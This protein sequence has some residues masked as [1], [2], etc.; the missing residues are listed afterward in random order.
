MTVYG[1]LGNH[2]ISITT[3]SYVAQALEHLGHTVARFQENTVAT[4]HLPAKLAA[5]GISTLFWTRTPS[6][7]CDADMQ[8][9][10][11]KECDR[12]G[13]RTVGLHLDKYWDLDRERDILEHPW[14][15]QD[16]VFTADGGNQDRFAD[17]GVN[18]EWWRPAIS[19]SQLGRG[20]HTPEY[21]SPVAFVGSQRYHREWP[22]R[23]QLIKHLNVT[24]RR[25]FRQFGRS[26]D[27]L[28]D[29]QLADAY[30][31]VDVVVG[32]SCLVGKHPSLYWS[33]R[34]PET[35]GRGGLLLHPYVQGIEDH[36]V[37]GEHLVLYKAGDWPGLKKLIDQWLKD[38]EG[39][40]RVKSAGMR[41]VAERDTFEI[42][43]ADVLAILGLAPAGIQ[44]SDIRT[45][46]TGDATPAG[47]S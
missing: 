36:Y 1:Y 43:M 23:Q 10:L 13:I 24:Y 19:A 6:Y 44:R 18:H 2:S 16:V 3:E 14:F 25:R 42:R 30:A 12:R 20:V 38:P 40:E 21:A 11:V 34:I 7:R 28:A 8:A 39:R 15:R 32:D 4:H 22:W 37:D 35:L 5:Q 17:A 31:S 41:R 29:H 27:R 45:L 46:K 47:A 26:G 33:N 9:W